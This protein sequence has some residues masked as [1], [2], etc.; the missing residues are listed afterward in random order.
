MTDPLVKWAG[1]KR[2]L[3]GELERRLPF[4]ADRR[5]HVE[6]FAGG[7]ALAFARDPGLVLLADVCAPLVALYHAVQCFPDRV[8]RSL[9]RHAD[10]HSRDH[11][12]RTR[13]RFNRLTAQLGPLGCEQVETKVAVAGAMLYLNRAG[14]NG[15]YRVNRRGEFNVPWGNRSAAAVYRPQ[16]I[17][18]ASTLLSG[19]SIVHMCFRESSKLVGAHDFVYLDPPYPPDHKGVGFHAYGAGGFHFDEHVELRDAAEAMA[20]RGARVMVSNANTAFVR[21]IWRRWRVEQV[22]VQRSIGASR[23]GRRRVR[24]VVIR[25]Y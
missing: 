20:E 12:R 10:K 25:S 17:R 4:D 21:D 16:A 18:A 23:A 11:Y 1:G 15:L 9:R 5:R 19:A 8:R 7:A 22:T 6:L 24:E 13:A 14:Y 3:T 2:R